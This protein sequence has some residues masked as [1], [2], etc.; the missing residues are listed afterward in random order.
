MEGG[1]VERTQ[2]NI[3]QIRHVKRKSKSRGGEGSGGERERKT[4]PNLGEVSG[5]IPVHPSSTPSL[6]CDARRSV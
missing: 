6:S 1:T 3:T 2:G 5:R 4:P